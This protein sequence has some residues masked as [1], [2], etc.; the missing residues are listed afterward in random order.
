MTP[1]GGVAGRCILLST[2]QNQMTWRYFEILKK[3]ATNCKIG[4]LQGAG[5]HPRVAQV[6]DRNLFVSIKSKIEEIEH[7]R[8]NRCCGL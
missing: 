4:G 3:G 1:L 5:E 8:N 7:L 2:F 6:L